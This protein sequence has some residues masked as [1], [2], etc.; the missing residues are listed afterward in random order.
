MKTVLSKN[1]LI[2]D[3]KSATYAFIGAFLFIGILAN[4]LN[5]FDLFSGINPNYVIGV[6]LVIFIL[7]KVII[8]S[9]LKKLNP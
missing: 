4:T 2:I 5:A 9:D 3:I 7:L 8:A 6:W 1:R